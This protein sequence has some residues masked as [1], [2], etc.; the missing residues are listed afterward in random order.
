MRDSIC[1]SSM[2]FCVVLLSACSVQPVKIASVPPNTFDSTESIGVIWLS[3][4]AKRHAC[5]EEPYAAT[6]GDFVAHGMEGSLWKAAAY[7]ADQKLIRAIK[8]LNSEPIVRTH[9]IDIVAKAIEG[10]DMGAFIRSDP[11]Y[12]G[13]L[14]ATSVAKNL[15]MSPKGTRKSV[16]FHGDS[17]VKVEYDLTGIARD[18]STD[19]LLVLQVIEYG[20]RRAFG[21]FG[22][23][24]GAPYTAAGVRAYMIDSTNGKIL[25][26]DVAY[27][28]FSVGE[29]YSRRNY[30]SVLRAANQAL[31]SAVTDVTNTIVSALK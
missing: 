20:V 1:I 27:Y 3:R 12:P 2:L 9:F 13:D 8:K 15:R 14:R 25:L 30:K 7:A 26:D 21:E 19:Y 29:K 4:C 18:L 31:S 28:E 6:S 11:I 10:R 24:T 16:A 17:M 22:L 5:I 23:P